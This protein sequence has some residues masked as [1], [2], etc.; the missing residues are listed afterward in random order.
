MHNN[1]PLLIRHFHADNL[2]LKDFF[3]NE[4]CVLRNEVISN[5]HYF[6]QVLADANISS[7]ASKVIAKME[8]LEKENMELKRIAIYKEIIIQNLSSNKN[9]MKEIPKNDKTDCPTN[10]SEEY[11]FSESVTECPNTPK[12]TSIK[13]RL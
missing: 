1:L 3:I 7:Q 5:K 12:K 10:K 2:A 11:S 9:I 6:D 8:L 13:K 4:I